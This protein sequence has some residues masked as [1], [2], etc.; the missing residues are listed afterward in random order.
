MA[1]ALGF[2]NCLYLPLIR[3]IPKV[4]QN[5]IPEKGVQ[6]QLQP[7][8]TSVFLTDVLNP[9]PLAHIT[10]MGEEL[11]GMFT[12]GGVYGAYMVLAARDIKIE[13]IES[14]ETSEECET[15]FGG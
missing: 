6:E 9:E 11:A 7:V 3:L 12:E 5:N 4:H 1:P 13:E 14:E 15:Q 8:N 10:A 2:E